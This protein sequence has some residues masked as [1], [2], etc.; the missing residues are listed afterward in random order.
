MKRYY[1]DN[2]INKK[3]L[4]MYEFIRNTKT[5][6]LVRLRNFFYLEDEFRRFV[7]IDEKTIRKL[8]VEIETNNLTKV[9]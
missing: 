4:E 1:D 2:L 5:Y 7:C 6:D 8:F 3:L 9:I